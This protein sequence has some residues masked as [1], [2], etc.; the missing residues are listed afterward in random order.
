MNS[1]ERTSAMGQELPDRP[2]YSD[3]MLAC[4][5]DRKVAPLRMALT[6]HDLKLSQLSWIFDLNF[7]IRFRTLLDR[8]YIQDIV[9]TLPRE[10][11]IADASRLLHEYAGNNARRKGS[12]Q[13]GR[14]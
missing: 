9:S 5:F 3:D 4:I 6:L 11:K 10:E 1:R 14:L 2:G 7:G 8:N 12:A 13:N